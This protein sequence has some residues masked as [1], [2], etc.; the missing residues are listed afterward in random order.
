MTPESFC[1][2]NWKNRIAINRDKTECRRNR[3]GGES[4]FSFGKTRSETSSPGEVSRRL[5]IWSGVP[6]RAG[7]SFKFECQRLIKAIQNRKTG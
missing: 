4:E 5:H 6:V 2:R 7:W 3:S 1:P